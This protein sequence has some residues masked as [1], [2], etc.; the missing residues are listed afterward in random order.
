MLK[1][2]LIGQ[3]AAKKTMQKFTLTTCRKSDI[4]ITWLKVQ[5]LSVRSR[6]EGGSKRGIHERY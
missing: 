3:S 2:T 4:I 6:A 5:R 1:I